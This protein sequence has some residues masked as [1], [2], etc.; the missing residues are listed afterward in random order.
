MAVWSIRPQPREVYHFERR[1]SYGHNGHADPAAE[2]A[3]RWEILLPPPP[4]RRLA[5]APPARLCERRVLTSRVPPR[6]TPHDGL[7]PR[8]DS[9]A[10]SVRGARPGVES[11]QG[12]ELQSRVGSARLS[13]PAWTPAPRLLAAAAPTSRSRARALSARPSRGAVGGGGGRS[14]RPNLTGE[15]VRVV[16]CG[17]SARAPDRRPATARARQPPRG[18]GPEVP[19]TE[20]GTPS[21]SRGLME[22]EMLE[23]LDTRDHEAEEPA[24]ALG[25]AGDF[26]RAISELGEPPARIRAPSPIDPATPMKAGSV[27]AW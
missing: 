18:G 3:A 14:V 8:A 12:S 11:Q 17:G 23:R 1:H 5:S 19:G 15:L 27:S 24:L 16:A 22:R 4:R 2:S 26:G 20:A 7:P 10:P 13:R 9:A 21:E 25:F 6:P